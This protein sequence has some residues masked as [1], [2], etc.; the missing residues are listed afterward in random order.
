[1]M[2]ILVVLMWQREAINRL[3]A[4]ETN[5]FGTHLANDY[6]FGMSEEQKLAYN[7][8]GGVNKKILN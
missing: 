2:F 1:M 5:F 6:M 4:I 7:S 3:M 8:V